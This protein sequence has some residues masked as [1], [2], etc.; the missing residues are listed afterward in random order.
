[1]SCE[2][3]SVPSGSVAQTLDEM[4]FERGIWSAALY[5]DAERVRQLLTYGRDVDAEDSSGYT[6]LH[7]AARAG[8]FDIC[9]MLLNAGANVN[10]TTRAGQATPLHR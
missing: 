3:C 2:N 6:A 7:Y 9:R 10:A 4:D 5:N 8:H 1:M